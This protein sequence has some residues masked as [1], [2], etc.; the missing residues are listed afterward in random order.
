VSLEIVNFRCPQQWAKQKNRRSP[1]ENRKTMKPTPLLLTCLIGLAFP[2]VGLAQPTITTQ[3]KNQ[4]VSLG[5]KVTFTIRA[6][7]TSLGYQWRHNDAAIP[8]A[9]SISLVLTNIQLAN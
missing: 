9:T 3:P 8:D 5:E 2:R 6:S 7:G 1:P 4:S